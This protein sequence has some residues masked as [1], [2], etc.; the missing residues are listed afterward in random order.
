M[1]DTL[2]R[3]MKKMNTTSRRSARQA[4][5]LAV[6]LAP[7]AVVQ[8]SMA[9]DNRLIGPRITAGQLL[10]LQNRQM[11]QDFQQRQQFNRELDSLS[12]QRQPQINI[13]VMKPNC[14]PRRLGDSSVSQTCS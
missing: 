14:R 2:K 10:N 13:P 7:I 1:C 11:R 6:V 5:F 8:P 4:I 12:N 9:N 3:H